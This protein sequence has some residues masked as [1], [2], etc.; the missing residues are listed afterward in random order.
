MLLIFFRHFVKLLA[1]VQP[2]LDY[3]WDIR[4]DWERECK[5]RQLCI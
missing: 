1:K 5:E 3:F 2:L 4:R